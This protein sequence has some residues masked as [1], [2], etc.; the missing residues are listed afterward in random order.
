M[1]TGPNRTHDPWICNGTRYRLRYRAQSI[2]LLNV[3]SNNIFFIP[4]QEVFDSVC[5]LDTSGLSYIHGASRNPTK[6]FDFMAQLLAHPL[7]RPLQEETA[8]RIGSSIP[9][10]ENG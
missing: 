5:D 1:G 7:Q 6:L 2:C 3:L 10:P 4:L 9:T 8:Y